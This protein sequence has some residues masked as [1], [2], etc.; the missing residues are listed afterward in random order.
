MS[1]LYPNLG[2]VADELCI[3]VQ[4]TTTP[5]HE[6]GLLMMNS[7]NQQPIVPAWDPG[8]IRIGNGK[9]KRQGS[10]S[11]CPQPAVGPALWGNSFRLGFIKDSYQQLQGGSE[12][13]D[14]PHQ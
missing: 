9:R 13:C 3:C 2:K 5:N 1:E 12:E 6:P 11:W 7:G 8:H 10:W 14:R 4:H